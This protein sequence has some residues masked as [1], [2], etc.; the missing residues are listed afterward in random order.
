MLINK[1]NNSMEHNCNNC[2]NECTGLFNQSHSKLNNCSRWTHDFVKDCINNISLKERTLLEG[3]QNLQSSVENPKESNWIQ[4][5][6][7]ISSMLT[8]E[9][10]MELMD[11]REEFIK[12]KMKEIEKREDESEILGMLEDE[13]YDEEE[14]N[15]LLGASYLN[16]SLNNDNK[17]KKLVKKKDDR[18]E[19]S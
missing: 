18:N 13:D 6:Q 8:R 15:M 10:S 9:K 2:N 1:L 12:E 14:F 3:E 17:G 11:A 5:I 4:E 16:N 7:E 19:S